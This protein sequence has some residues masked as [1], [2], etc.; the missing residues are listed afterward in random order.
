MGEAIPSY[1][2]PNI[3][4]ITDDIK[5]N[6][7][8]GCGFHH[9]K[10]DWSNSCIFKEYIQEHVIKFVPRG[11]N[12]YLLILFDGSTTHISV[13]L[14]EW[15]IQKK[16]ILFVFPPHASHFLQPMDVGRLSKMDEK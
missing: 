6:A 13:P 14:I 15:A 7:I 3:F 5:V 12:D 1:L 2:I 10:N 9:S 4:K 11:E 8:P 16:V